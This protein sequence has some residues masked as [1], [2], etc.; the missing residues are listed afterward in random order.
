MPA[1]VA[2][3]TDFGHADHYVGA[4]KGA[5]L[6][7][8]PEATVVDIVH[9][10]PAHDVLAGAYSL[11]AAYRAFPAGTVFVAVVDPGVGSDRRALAM[12]AGGYLFVGPDNGIL[13]LV[14]A[15][16]EGARVHEITNALLFAREVSSTF[17][18]RDIFGPVAGHLA[19]GTPLEAVGPAVRDPLQLPIAPLRQVGPG[20]WEAAVLHVDRFGNLITT[21]TQAGL[22]AIL[23]TVDGDPSQLVVIVEGTIMPLTR[24]YSDVAVGEPC[25][26][27][28][29]AGRL[30]VAVH[31][32]AAS[33]LL[34][35]GRGAPVRVRKAF[36]SRP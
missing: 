31:R 5:V 11:A 24:A 9:E 26:L 18:A 10:L 12:D 1:V 6:V 33:R 36:A 8:C 34:G 2:L 3:V 21:L 28:G 14:L 22:G 20:E 23:D 29:S 4:V 27:V 16:H 25:A 15:E 19:R 32:G 35:A 17:H 7:S 30:E 13:G